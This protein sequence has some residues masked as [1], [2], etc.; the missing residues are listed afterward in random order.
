MFNQL[1]SQREKLRR[2]SHKKAI[3]STVTYAVKFSQYQCT[4]CICVVDTILM[5]AMQHFASFDETNIR[6]AG[7]SYCTYGTMLSS[8]KV[9]YLLE[10]QEIHLTQAKVITM[11]P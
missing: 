2:L 11:P 1:I 8:C 9:P 5:V 10:A 7:S 6:S 3:S 4:M